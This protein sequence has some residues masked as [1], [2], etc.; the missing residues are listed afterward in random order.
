MKQVLFLFSLIIFYHIIILNHPSLA[1]PIGCLLVLIIDY[2][3]NANYYPID[4]NNSNIK[5]KS[6]IQASTIK[7]IEFNLPESFKYIKTKVEQPDKYSNAKS[8]MQYF[9]E[10]D[11]KSYI[12]FE[13]LSYPHDIGL[14]TEVCECMLYF[15]GKSITNNNPIIDTTRI[16]FNKDNSIRYYD[17]ISAY[18]DGKLQCNFDIEDYN[19]ID[20]GSNIKVKKLFIL[21]GSIVYYVS[22]I[23]KEGNFILD[24]DVIKV[25]LM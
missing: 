6:S 25:I 13:K 19:Y 1:V 24:Q 23:R 14:V 3:I 4:K 11:T 22:E 21:D 9:Y 10:L 8:I 7:K 18:T 17:V 20:V 15:S 5:N 12:I 2:Y 16:C